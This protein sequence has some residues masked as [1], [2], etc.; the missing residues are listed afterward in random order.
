MNFSNLLES[1][2]SSRQRRWLV[3]GAAGFIGSHLIEYLLKKGQEVVGLDNFSSGS[4]SNLEE[5]RCAVGSYWKSFQLIEGDIR[6]PELCDNAVGDCEFVLHHAALASVPHSFEN[7]AETNE[8]NVSG[9]VNI[10]AA[11][12]RAGVARIVFASSSAVYGDDVTLPKQEKSI[13]RSLS[14][15]AL[16]KKVNEEIAESYSRFFGMNL[17]GLRYFNVYGPRQRADGPYAAVIPIWIGNLLAG[18]PVIVFGD[19]SNTRDFCFV[20]DIVR[21]NV[22]AALKED[23][24]GYEVFNVGKGSA[25]SLLELYSK[26]EKVC[27]GKPGTERLQFAPPR[28]G[29]IVHSTADIGKARHLL[30]FHADTE[31]EKGLEATVNWFRARKEKK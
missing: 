8:V 17:V 18:K 25:T 10:M 15:Y 19:G 27:S 16:S 13:G 11:A 28:S 3:T 5:V 1:H 22:H 20:D 30:E 14:P 2:L 24:S 12:K 23:F 21:V 31:L 4:K 26:L 9:F 7:P 6:D 29:D